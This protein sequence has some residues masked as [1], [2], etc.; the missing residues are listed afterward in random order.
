MEHLSVLNSSQFETFLAALNVAHLRQLL[1]CA[2]LRKSGKRQELVDRL[3]EAKSKATVPRRGSNV[4]D[5]PLSFPH[6]GGFTKNT[7]TRLLQ[8]LL[9]VK[10]R[11]T[12]SRAE[13]VH[14]SSSSQSE[15]RRK[16]RKRQ[17]GSDRA[18][19]AV[20]GRPRV[21]RRRFTAKDL[22]RIHRARNQRFFLITHR[23]NQS[24]SSCTMRVLGSTGNVYVVKIGKNPTCSCPDKRRVPV[25][26]HLFFVYL[27]VAGLS[28]TDPTIV[29]AE[30]SDDDLDMIIGRLRSRIRQLD[31][32][33]VADVRVRAAVS[34][35]T[36]ASA[37]VKRH[38]IEAEP[39]SICFEDLDKQ[40][41]I[42]W[43]ENSCGKNFHADCLDR[44]T[45][46]SS[47]PTCPLCRASIGPV[48]QPKGRRYTNLSHLQPGVSSQRDMSIYS[49]WSRR[50][51]FIDWE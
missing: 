44:W 35:K 11:E 33:Y 31:E 9:A 46:A 38:P 30:H 3:V 24:N 41:K 47:S 34:G 4:G 42:S 36:D 5:S 43:C 51:G 40:S 45:Q 29:Q 21:R 2:Q 37:K 22:D 20:G 32:N 48:S 6:T 15:P 27:R 12:N 25:C 39:C 28:H 14:P 18:A 26:K 23:F 16:K 13:G 19:R 10:K 17:G 50:R 7:A 49:A 8:Q 1:G